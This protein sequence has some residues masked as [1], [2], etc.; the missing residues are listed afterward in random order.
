M[1]SVLEIRCKVYHDERACAHCEGAHC[2]GAHDIRCDR[3]VDSLRPSQ[4]SLFVSQVCSSVRMAKCKVIALTLSDSDS[5][6]DVIQK[7]AKLEL[8]SR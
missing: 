7:K 3:Q 4:L 2:E 5:D 1:Q 6:G 8:K